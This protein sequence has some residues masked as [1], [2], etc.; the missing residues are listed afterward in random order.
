MHYDAPIRAH[1][2]A[3]WQ[4]NQVFFVDESLRFYIE[5][6]WYLLGLM[7]HRKILRKKY[8]ITRIN[9]EP[10]KYPGGCWTVWDASL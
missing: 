4:Q 3:R 5:E 10:I 2:R 8:G 7:E 9:F 1:I 6:E